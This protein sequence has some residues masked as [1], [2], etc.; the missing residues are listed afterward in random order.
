MTYRV[1]FVCGVL[2]VVAMV[3]ATMCIATTAVSV[4]AGY[5]AAVAALYTICILR[6]RQ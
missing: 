1:F 5:G 2:I 6:P 4:V 3:V